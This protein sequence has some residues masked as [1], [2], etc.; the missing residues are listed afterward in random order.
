VK[1]GVRLR[2]LELPI[3]SCPLKRTLFFLVS[4]GVARESSHVNPSSLLKIYFLSIPTCKALVRERTNK[5][6]N[7]A[8]H[9]GPRL[10][11]V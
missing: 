9:R 7:P 11:T 1:P 4:E 3:K 6:F 10:D 2:I 8:L 5:G